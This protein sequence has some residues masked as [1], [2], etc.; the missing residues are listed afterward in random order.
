MPLMGNPAAAVLYPG[1]LVFAAVPYAW[2]AR[3]YIVLH[4]ALAFVA[5]LVLLR[6]WRISWQGTGLGTL[7]YAFGAPILFQHSN[8]IYLVGAAWLPL[9]IH[10]V[11]R[12]VRLGR[13]WGLCQLAAVLA[14]Q[15]LGGTRRLRIY[16]D[17]R[18]RVTRSGWRGAAGYAS[19]RPRPSRKTRAAE[20]ELS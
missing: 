12:R 15:V 17:W 19:E 14:M 9:G 1:K 5:M 10:A 8:A 2:G 6:S 11:D 3:I 16:W 13:R 18:G 20:P 4:T 7:S